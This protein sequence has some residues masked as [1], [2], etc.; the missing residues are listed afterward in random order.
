MLCENNIGFIDIIRYVYR[1]MYLYIMF[2]F[3]LYCCILEICKYRM[4][5][6]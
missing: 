3:R 2:I 4:F 1:I 5:S 6:K